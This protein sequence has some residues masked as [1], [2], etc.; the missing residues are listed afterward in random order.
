MMILLLLVVGCG[1]DRDR[2][3]TILKINI[4]SNPPD[5]DPALSNDTS[6]QKV[7][8]GLMEPLTRLDGDLVPRPG[9]AVS[10]EHND[11]YTRWDFLLREDDRW[12]NG[13]PV[14]AHDYLYSLQRVLTP[15]MASPRAEALF[16]LLVG[17]R[18]YFDA[19]GLNGTGTLEGVE[20]LE[21]D[22]ILRFNLIAP[23]P[24]LSVYTASTPFVPVHRGTI[25]RHG[26][27]WTLSPDTFIGNGPFRMTRW[28]DGRVVR[29]E[30]ADTWWDADNV[31]WSTVEFLMIDSDATAD[32]A[33]R[34]GDLDVV[35]LMP[36]EVDT[37]RDK[38]EAQIAPGLAIYY[39]IFNARME[40]FDDREVRRALSRA[41][42][43]R[44]IT[45]DITRA[46]ELPA[47][48]IVPSTVQG[49]REGKTYREVAGDMI[50]PHSVDE[51]RRIL[52]EAGYSSS[53]PVPALTFSYNTAETNKLIAEQLQQ[54]W[55][56]L[57]IADVRIN[58]MEWGV[59]LQEARAGRLQT[60]RMGWVVPP[61]PM[62]FLEIFTT[63]HPNNYAG[64]SN[65]DFDDL[66]ER[67]LHERDMERREDLLIEAERILLEKDVAVAPILVYTLPYLISAD[68]EGLRVNSLDQ[69]TYVRARRR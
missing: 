33:F 64:Y 30:K 50:G 62:L 68:I 26:E 38:P 23:D 61:D 9:S 25:E 56:R 39:V 10:W 7:L 22:S 60:F 55:S 13:D 27:R 44:M 28:D 3:P 35:T 4:R 34:S 21:D 46:G 2:D 17:A 41:I 51:A 52:E 20:I 12:H 31:W 43:R 5:L 65:A 40:P 59:Y 66:L 11:D 67:A 6:S 18:E 47:T 36:T 45:R 24:L 32:A 8:H 63:D 48:G 58:N 14:T 42:N 69:L 57:P 53:N 54:M 15:E 16:R 37:W 29:L 19:G 49:A 1:G